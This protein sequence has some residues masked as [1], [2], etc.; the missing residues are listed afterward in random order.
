MENFSWLS[1]LVFL[2]VFAVAV[3]GW[4]L[5]SFWRRDHDR[6]VARLRDLGESQAQTPG[7]EKPRQAGALP[8]AGR[9]LMPKEDKQ[10]AQWKGKLIQ[11]GLYHPN[12]LPIFLGVKLILLVVLPLLLAGVPALA[13]LFGL[14]GTLV[15]CM[16]GIALAWLGP[17][18]WLEWHVARRMRMLRAALP[19][20]LDMLVLCLEGGVSLPAGLQRVSEELPWVHPEL[21]LEFT[22]VQ[23]EV[24]MG[25]SPGEAIKRFG[26]RCQIES[27]R[28]LAGLVL[29]A[30]RYGGSVAKSLRIHADSWRLERQQQAEEQAQKAAV[31][32]LFPMLLCIF[33]AIFL[34]TLGPAALQLVKLFSH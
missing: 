27:L 32:I 12:A 17:N 7:D 19:D 22:I 11:A 34:V 1:M 16:I 13:G 33:P 4:A 25:L 29:Q 26:E 30:E 23:R 10:N 9:L 24:E 31:K 21:A 28:E 18:L 2:G 3:G 20:A 15:A 8:M 14:Q 5:W 6:A